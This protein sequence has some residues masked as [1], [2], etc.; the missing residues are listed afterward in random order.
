MRKQMKAQWPYE[1]LHGPLALRIL[2]FGEARLDADNAAG[3]AMDC[4]TGILWGDDRV[5]LIPVLIVEWQ[6]APKAE[7]KWIIQITCL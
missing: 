6:K 7:S 4:G 2:L 3:A 1:P 5:N